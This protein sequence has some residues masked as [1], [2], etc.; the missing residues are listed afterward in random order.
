L[1]CVGAGLGRDLNIPAEQIRQLVTYLRSLEAKAPSVPD[2]RTEA[3][4]AA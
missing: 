4:A 3:K 1:L 2:W